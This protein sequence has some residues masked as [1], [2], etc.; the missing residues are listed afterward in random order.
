MPISSAS[1]QSPTFN[2]RYRLPKVPKRPKKTALHSEVLSGS[3]LR[4]GQL[5]EAG[6]NINVQDEAGRTALHDAID[7]PESK[8]LDVIRRL[9]T[10]PQAATIIDSVDRD[11][12]TALCWAVQLRQMDIVKILVASGANTM[13]ATLDGDML[14]HQCL[15]TDPELAKLIVQTWIDNNEKL[16]KAHNM[17][18]RNK[19]GETPLQLAVQFH[20]TAH[21]E[22]FD[23][24]CQAALYG[25]L[26]WEGGKPPQRTLIEFGDTH[27]SESN[28]FWNAAFPHTW[29]N[30]L[31]QP[32]AQQQSQDA[33]LHVAGRIGHVV[34]FRKFMN[35]IFRGT[36]EVWFKD[37]QTRKF[38]AA[39]TTENTNGESP[40]HLLVKEKHW[41]A[42]RAILDPRLFPIKLRHRLLGQEAFTPLCE[43]VE[44]MLKDLGCKTFTAA[45]NPLEWV[46]AGG[47]TELAN[48]ILERG[49]NRVVLSRALYQAALRGHV[50]VVNA[51]LA[52]GADPN[53]RVKDPSQA[54]STWTPLAAAAAWG[55]VQV[56][57]ALL[58]CAGIQPHLATPHT[59]KGLQGRTCTPLG[60]AV[61]KPHTEVVELFSKHQLSASGKLNLNLGILNKDGE[62]LLSPL[63]LAIKHGYWDIASCLLDRS[64]VQKELIDLNVRA[65]YG[66]TLLQ[67][68]LKQLSGEHKDQQGLRSCIKKLRATG[69][70]D[71]LGEIIHKSERLERERLERERLE[72]ERL[73]RERDRLIMEELEM[74]RSERDE[75]AGETMESYSNDD[76][77][78]KLG[79]WRRMKVAGKVLYKEATKSGESE[80]TE[81]G[82]KIAEAILK[83]VEKLRRKEEEERIKREKKEARKRETERK[84]AGY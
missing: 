84:E 71:H 28:A 54:G 50:E 23:L 18:I 6:V 81:I 74:E 63:Q 14:L 25:L 11:D 35:S 59:K 77:A 32:S 49:S 64:L 57:Q 76:D 47:Y 58:G 19:M 37:S 44:A 38:L 5:C 40:L 68:A 36:P 78:I 72:R 3:E 30:L 51:L 65:R 75:G 16:K 13:A 26:A 82:G 17:A 66:E 29:F 27:K 41:E 24:M 45:T 21:R 42:L 22:W 9:L 48:S 8:R 67:Q 53:N 80:F 55:H 62:P 39:M 61:I 7:C 20:H 56:A 33:A 43:A 60:L 1:L 70:F 4:V 34:F 2:R 79:R 31:L 15:K 83:E 52:H 73:E 46:A 12:R 69:H 10:H